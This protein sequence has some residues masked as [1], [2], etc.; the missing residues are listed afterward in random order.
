M[1]IQ[2]ITL[3]GNVNILSY[4]DTIFPKAATFPAPVAGQPAVSLGDLITQSELVH[5]IV[6]VVTG[7]V[8]LTIVSMFVDVITAGVVI[9]LPTV[10]GNTGLWYHITN[11][12][13]GTITID[14]YGSELINGEL[15]QTLEPG[16]S[17]SIY[18][19]GSAWRIY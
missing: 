16:E 1:T 18:T 9:G 4:D 6:Q 10:S 12:S 14:G 8:T 11:A 2:K 13:T 15:T 5:Q 7:N 17:M 3:G 19:E